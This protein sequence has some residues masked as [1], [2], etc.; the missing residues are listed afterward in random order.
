MVGRLGVPYRFDQG[1][2]M[3]LELLKG[4]AGRWAFL[5][6]ESKGGILESY[7]DFMQKFKHVFDHSVRRADANWDISDKEDA[8][9]VSA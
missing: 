2:I 6:T 3:F 4:K 9:N 5:L 1:D 8:E 7:Q